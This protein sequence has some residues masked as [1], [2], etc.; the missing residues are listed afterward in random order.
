MFQ[1]RQNVGLNQRFMLHSMECLAVIDDTSIYIY[2]IYICKFC[3]TSFYCFHDHSVEMLSGLA[4]FFT[5]IQCNNYLCSC[6]W[7][8]LFLAYVLYCHRIVHKYIPTISLGFYA[9]ARCNSCTL[10]SV[11]KRSNLSSVHPVWLARLF[12]LFIPF[13]LF[14]MYPIFH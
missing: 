8:L 4:A 12:E 7:I 13:T 14:R 11:S 10:L 6:D 9:H 2:Y 5:D 1:H 3:Q